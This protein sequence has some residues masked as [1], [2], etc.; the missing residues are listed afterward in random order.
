MY[1][2]PFNDAPVSVELSV[3]S[4]SIAAIPSYS[5][6]IRGTDDTRHLSV[7]ASFAREC[8]PSKMVTDPID[9]YCVTFEGADRYRMAIYLFR[10]LSA[11]G[12][13]RI[14]WSSDSC[15]PFRG[16]VVVRSGVEIAAFISK[17]YVFIGFN[18]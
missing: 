2:N 6:I 3:S 16:R 11:H 9:G 7:I 13:A 14:V 17:T 4:P 8:C 5:P 10:Y 18:N 1:F 15:R 12:M